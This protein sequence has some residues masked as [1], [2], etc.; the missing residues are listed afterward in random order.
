MRLKT[1]NFFINEEISISTLDDA[2]LKSTKENF[3]SVLNEYRTYILANIEYNLKT[4]KVEYINFDKIDIK[5]IMRELT[6]EFT[7]EFI[8]EL[9]VIIFIIYFVYI[10][11]Q[12]I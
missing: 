9:N 10:L 2:T 8:Q 3:M 5:V 1:F 4:N 7:A 12:I 6:N 11:K